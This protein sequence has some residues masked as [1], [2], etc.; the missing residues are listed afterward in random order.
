MIKLFFII[1]LFITEIRQT[2]LIHA[3][4]SFLKKYFGRYNDYNQ[5]LLSRLLSGGIVQNKKKKNFIVSINNVISW[6][7]MKNLAPF[8]GPKSILIIGASR[9]AFTFNG[10]LVKNLRESRYPQKGKIFIVHP[11]AEEI[12]GVKC[13]HSIKESK[14]SPITV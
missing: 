3:E 14:L 13:F 6:K 12:M 10:T 8:F 9:N 7:L 1:I 11:E 5:F 2:V 4:R